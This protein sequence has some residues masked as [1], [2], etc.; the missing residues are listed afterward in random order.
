M[1]DR[2]SGKLPFGICENK[3]LEIPL[4]EYIHCSFGDMTCVV[5]LLES[6]FKV[7]I[8]DQLCCQKNYFC[9]TQYVSPL[10]L[11]SLPA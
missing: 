4:W 7:D 10:N 11:N 8:L 2:S 1:R 6:Q 5:I 9:M 3:K